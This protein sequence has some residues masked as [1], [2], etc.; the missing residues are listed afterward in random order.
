MKE[1][2]I[3]LTRKQEKIVMTVITS[4]VNSV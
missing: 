1:H 3:G 2:F 4:N